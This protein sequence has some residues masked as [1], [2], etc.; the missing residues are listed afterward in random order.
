MAPELV[1]MREE[2]LAYPWALD[3]YRHSPRSHPH[4]WQHVWPFCVLLKA[5]YNWQPLCAYGSL[6]A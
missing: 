5:A 4:A 1:H 6:L 3:V 2:R